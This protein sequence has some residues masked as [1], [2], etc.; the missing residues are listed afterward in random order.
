[1]CETIHSKRGQAT[2]LQER[3]ENLGSGL[4]KKNRNSSASSYLSIPMIRPDP[5]DAEKVA[6]LFFQTIFPD[7][8]RKPCVLKKRLTSHLSLYK[9][10]FQVSCTLGF[11]HVHCGC[12]ESNPCKKK[13]TLL[14]VA[15]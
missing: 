6:C 13:N 3:G 14:F 15:K 7:S 4:V 2:F 9:L 11:K 10:S 8:A 5:D 12:G 1:M